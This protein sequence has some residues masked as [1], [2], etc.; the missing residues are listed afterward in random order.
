LKCWSYYEL[1]IADKHVFIVAGRQFELAIAVINNQITA[2]Q[3]KKP[4]YLPIATRFDVLCPYSRIETI[5]EVIRKDFAISVTADRRIAG[6][7]QHRNREQTDEKSQN[8]Y[9]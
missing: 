5:G 2:A 4:A 3:D 1:S 7:R 8:W 9:H 6:P